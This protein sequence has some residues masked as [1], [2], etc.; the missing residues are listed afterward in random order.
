VKADLKRR[1][2]FAILDITDVTGDV[3]G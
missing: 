2:T 3:A 1:L